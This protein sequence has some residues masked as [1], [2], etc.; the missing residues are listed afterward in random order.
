PDPSAERDHQRHG[1]PRNE[2]GVQGGRPGRHAPAAGPGKAGRAANPVRRL[3]RG[4]GGQP[5]S[6]GQAVRGRPRRRTAGGIARIIMDPKTLRFRLGLFVITTA[7]L[8]AVLILLFGGSVGGLFVRQNEYIIA[9]KEA[10][11]V[12]KGTP[13]RRSGVKIGAV[14]KVELDDRTGAVSLTI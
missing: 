11:G 5:R 7:V 1:H 8:L 10:P 4:T 14:T 9:L 12:T 13:V 6:A 3:G 2:D